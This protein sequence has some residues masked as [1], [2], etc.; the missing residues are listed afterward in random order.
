MQRLQV[1]FV[2]G[3]FVAVTSVTSAFSPTLTRLFHTPARSCP[4]HHNETI[5]RLLTTHYLL[6]VLV[7]ALTLCQ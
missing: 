5:T 7:V 2:T 6:L 1:D 3:D 4:Q